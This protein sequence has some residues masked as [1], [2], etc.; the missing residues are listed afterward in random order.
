MTKKNEQIVGKKIK[1]AMIEADLSPKELAKKLGITQAAIS[2]WI[3]GKGNPK[4]STLQKF[5]EATGKTLNY[6]F[7]NN[8]IGDNNTIAI[9]GQK[10]NS[11]AI[12]LLRK[13]IELLKK[14]I[15]N[16]NLRLQ[17][18]QNKKKKK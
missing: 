11:A 8:N 3:V 13:D 17:L 15:D 1:A 7:D 16:I 12:E 5:A 18:N 14:E 4:V 6:F 10:D 9:G 2:R